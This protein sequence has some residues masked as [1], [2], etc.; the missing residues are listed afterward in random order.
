[1]SIQPSAQA[2]YPA[3]RGR[4]RRPPRDQDNQPNLDAS[5]VGLE[6]TNSSDEAFEALW[7]EKT[8]ITSRGKST[9]IVDSGATSHMCNERSLFKKLSKESPIRFIEVADGG[10]TSVE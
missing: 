10:K 6:R 1:M 5:F 3:E 4:G 9:W 8:E 2:A 7:S